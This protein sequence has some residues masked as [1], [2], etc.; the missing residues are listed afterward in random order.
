MK[1]FRN[2]EVFLLYAKI[3]YV[4]KKKNFYC[5]ISELVIDAEKKPIRAYSEKEMR[6][7]EK[8]INKSLGRI[9]FISTI[10][11][12]NAKCLHRVIAQYILFRKY[13]C[14]PV[15]LVIGVKKFPFSSHIWLE[16]EGKD[17]ALVC[18]CEENIVGYD[19]IFDSDKHI[20]RL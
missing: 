1:A 13:Y 5:L 2:V 12:R 18:E 19:V 6:K 15:K 10:Y 16:W 20:E 11:F 4:L 17:H 9:E 8:K 3:D 7:V 14:L